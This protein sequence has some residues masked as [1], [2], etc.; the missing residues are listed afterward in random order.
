MEWSQEQTIRSIVV[1][2]Y[3]Q[4]FNSVAPC[5]LGQYD[6]VHDFLR[7]SEQQCNASA[8][9]DQ[10]FLSAALCLLYA[11]SVL[12]W[13]ATRPTDVESFHPASSCE[14]HIPMEE[15]EVSILGSVGPARTSASC[16][17]SLPSCISS[18]QQGRAP[19]PSHHDGM[20]HGGCYHIEVSQ[21]ILPNLAFKDP[22][23]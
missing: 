8:C 9:Q 21:R 14:R 6:C 15:R 1:R 18:L 11:S 13:L 20:P 22:A 5:R 7:G 23:T 16:R 12:E 2:D 3:M 19:C 4:Q 10:E 17:A